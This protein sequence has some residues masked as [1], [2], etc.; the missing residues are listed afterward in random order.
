MRLSKLRAVVAAADSINAV[1]SADGPGKACSCLVSGQGAKLFLT[2][3]TVFS[4][5][6][7]Q[8]GID[9]LASLHI[10]CSTVVFK[11]HT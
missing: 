1:M 7:G 4:S 2:S 6:P 3:F 9:T 5:R 8:L 10:N 11:D